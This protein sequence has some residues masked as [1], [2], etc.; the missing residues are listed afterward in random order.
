MLS[1][2]PTLLLRGN[3]E[4]LGTSRS[5]DAGVKCG[6]SGLEPGFFTRSPGAFSRAGHSISGDCRQQSVHL[7]SVQAP[8]RN[9]LQSLRRASSGTHLPGS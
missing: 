2:L 1:I 4:Q 6:G 3:T 7:G 5:L 9:V 8:H